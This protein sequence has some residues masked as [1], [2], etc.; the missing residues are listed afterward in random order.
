MASVGLWIYEDRSSKAALLKQ[1]TGFEKLHQ[2]RWAWRKPNIISKS[3]KQMHMFFLPLNPFLPLIPTSVVLSSSLFSLLPFPPCVLLSL[4]YHSAPSFSSAPSFPPRYH[5]IDFLVPLQ[6][7]ND[8]QSRANELP[9]F[10]L[11][12]AGNSTEIGYELKCWHNL[13]TS[14]HHNDV[15]QGSVKLY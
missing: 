8:K 11:D 5:F 9:P 4:S 13:P 1:P 7:S 15:R 14:T 2:V 6:M 12:R 3:S 10:C